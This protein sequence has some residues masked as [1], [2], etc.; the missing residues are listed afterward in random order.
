ML[1]SDW[2]VTHEDYG[3]VDSTWYNYKHYN[4]VCLVKPPKLNIKETFIH[5]ITSVKWHYL[6]VLSVV[7]MLVG[8][9]YSQIQIRKFLAKKGI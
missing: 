6:L 2:T 3:K 9:K 4:K 7:M 1:K 5:K 8:R